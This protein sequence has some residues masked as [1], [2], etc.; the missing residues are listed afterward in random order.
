MIMSCLGT[1]QG[2]AIS[3]L[4]STKF[5][6]SDQVNS[7]FLYYPISVLRSS[8]P[9][10]KPVKHLRLFLHIHVVSSE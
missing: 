2:L 5:I 7:I 3:K 10:F 6:V 9:R 4:R 1:L 8:R